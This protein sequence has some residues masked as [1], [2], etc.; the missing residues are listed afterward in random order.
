MDYYK[1]LVYEAMQLMQK[2]DAC[3]SRKDAIDC[4]NKAT[5]LQEAADLVRKDQG[6]LAL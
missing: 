4:L 5:K 6:I 2:A 3:T 1:T